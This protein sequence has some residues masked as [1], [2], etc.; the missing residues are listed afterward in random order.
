[1]II[2]ELNWYLFDGIYLIYE[3]YYFREVQAATSKQ[4]QPPITREPPALSST[5][6]VPGTGKGRG[7]LR[8]QHPRLKPGSQG[9]LG[10]MGWL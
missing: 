9:N 2:K 4:K 7:D 8:S 1:M 3:I 6:L 10:A 5:R